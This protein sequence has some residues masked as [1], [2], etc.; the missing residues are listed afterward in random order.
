MRRFLGAGLT[1]VVLCVSFGFSI[2]PAG[3][4]ATVNPK[5]S[6]TFI[7]GNSVYEGFCTSRFIGGDLINSCVG[8]IVSGP[9]VSE[10][11]LFS[12]GNLHGVLTTSGKVIE[13]ITP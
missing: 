1:L 4:D 3:A 8:T 11:T 2:A 6:F 12:S 13:L 5:S 9:K 10:R 7:Y